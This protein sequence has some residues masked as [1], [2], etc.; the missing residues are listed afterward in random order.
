MV[1]D[2][3]RKPS[4]TSASLVED[5]YAYTHENYKSVSLIAYGRSRGAFCCEACHRLTG[6]QP[7]IIDPKTL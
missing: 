1:A 7:A 5:A 6:R 3:S 2:L 4:S